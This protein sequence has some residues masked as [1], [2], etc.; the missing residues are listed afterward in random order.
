MGID[1][2]DETELPILYG[3]WQLIPTDE[4]D[5]IQSES[6]LVKELTKILYWLALPVLFLFHGQ[7]ERPVNTSGFLHKAYIALV[8][9]VI[10]IILGLLYKY[11]NVP[12]SR[13]TIMIGIW[14]TMFAVITVIYAS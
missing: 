5:K 4:P 9:S 3:L 14:T 6:V 2:I 13:Q 7:S 8:I 10:P 1:E 12:F 11:K